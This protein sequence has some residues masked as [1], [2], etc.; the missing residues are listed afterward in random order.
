MTRVMVVAF[1]LCAGLLHAADGIAQTETTRLRGTVRD[2]VTGKPVSGA[3][4]SVSGDVA[5]QSEV[6][7]DR[8]FFRI[9][10]KG[11]TPGD[12]VRIRVRKSGYVVYDQQVISSEEQ[13]LDIPLRSS[14][15]PAKPEA[16]APS[17]TT[18]LRLQGNAF[19]LGF[20][21]Q[22]YTVFVG[23]VANDRDVETARTQMTKIYSI[24]EA[25]ARDFDIKLTR[26]VPTTSSDALKYLSE[27]DEHDEIG[28]QLGIKYGRPIK[29]WYEFA[30]YASTYLYYKD[31][32]NPA[33]APIVD[34]MRRNVQAVGG[35]LGISNRDVSQFIETP[36][37]STFRA[38]ARQLK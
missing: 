23:M 10:I 26:Q 34:S 14:A 17:N 1:L 21:T 33:M 30:L 22:S 37:A 6:T 3:S 19:D 9:L 16:P 5:Q 28:T 13:V 27:F 20:H 8:G 12:L 18:T 31:D 36:N 24:M 15:E 11:V 29:L 2:S 35:V 38:L 7:D 32:P 25:Y 4:V